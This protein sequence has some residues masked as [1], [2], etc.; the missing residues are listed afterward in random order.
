MTDAGPE[1]IELKSILATRGL[2]E[3]LRFL[4]DRTPHRF[5]GLYRYDGDMLRNVCLFDRYSPEARRG[6]DVVMKD[7]YCS[8]AKE[9]GEHL[10][11]ADA[12]TD[13]RFPHKNGS[14]VISYCGVVLRDPD[15]KPFGA[16][17]HYDTSPCQPRISD[18]PLLE[19]AGPLLVEAARE[20][21]PAGV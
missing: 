17:C 8:I 4:N 20:F 15:G 1:L 14:P 5:T 2:H 3:V 21:Q 12:R 6:D 7:A 13:G 10:A 18:M 16:L 19:A 9:A 11:F